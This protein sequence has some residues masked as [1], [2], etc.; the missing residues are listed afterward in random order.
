MKKTIVL[1]SV[2]LSFVVFMLFCTDCFARG[3]RNGG[4]QNGNRSQEYR[5]HPITRTK[6]ISHVR[7]TNRVRHTRRVYHRHHRHYHYDGECCSYNNCYDEP[8]IFGGIQIN[9]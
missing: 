9:L 2:L 4:F 5:S 1:V 7:H 3:R 8:V 6:H